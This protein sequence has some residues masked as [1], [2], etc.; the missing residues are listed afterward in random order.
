MIPTA[1]H[2]LEEESIPVFITQEARQLAQGFA[3][4][5]STPA[6]ADQVYRNTLAISVV[7]NYLRV[8]GIPTDLNHCDSW[9]PMM[10][11]VMNTA[12]LE[13]VGRGR[14]ECRPLSTEE[15]NGNVPTCYIP[16]EVQ[17]DRI[18]YIVVHLAEDEATLLGF[19]P[20]VKT[21]QLPLTQL[22]PFSDLLPHLHPLDEGE[23]TIIT[24]SQWFQDVMES[25]W[26]TLDDLLGTP[27]VQYRQSANAALAYREMGK[28]LSSDD[29]LDD[30]PVLVVRIMTS[31]DDMAAMTTMNIH[32]KVQPSP[33]QTAL[34][35]ELQLRL[36]DETGV[37]LMEAVN[38][39]ERQ[40]VML[41]FQAEVG[42]R[43]DVHIQWGDTILTERFVV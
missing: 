28:A 36:S 9:N 19:S 23:N 18:G 2:G 27:T 20:T 30:H 40:M 25:G 16:T 33:T 3:N 42:D 43:F 39:D 13:I 14:L 4:Q 38:I 7:N 26:Q 29:Q 41:D 22:Q 32:V 34:P 37:T 21:E 15:L 24:L 5:Q 31:A 17:G 11:M 35:P 6:K 10:R 12:D 8:L 1:L